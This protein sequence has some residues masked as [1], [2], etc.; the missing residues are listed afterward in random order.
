MLLKMAGTKRKKPFIIS[1]SDKNDGYSYQIMKNL[2]NVP[3]FALKIIFF[4]KTRLAWQFVTSDCRSAPKKSVT[5]KNPFIPWKTRKTHIKPEKPAGG[6][7]FYLTGGFLPTLVRMALQVYGFLTC[8]ARETDD[9]QL[10]A[11]RS[12]RAKGERASE[13]ALGRARDQL[14]PDR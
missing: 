13:G 11:E 4:Y 12:G 3:L 6:R 9:G 8:I 10:T 5:H 1:H 2:G 14:W 7:V